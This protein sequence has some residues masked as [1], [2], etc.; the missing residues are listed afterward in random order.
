MNMKRK[1]ISHTDAFSQNTSSY[2]FHNDISQV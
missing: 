1:K 2:A